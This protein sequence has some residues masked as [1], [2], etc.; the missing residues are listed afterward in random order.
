MQHP[1]GLR[2]S[3]QSQAWAVRM[4]RGF[5]L[6]QL[7]ECMLQPPLLS[8]PVAEPF[9]FELA[10]GIGKSLRA[11]QCCYQALESSE[12]I[13]R[14]GSLFL[15]KLILGQLSIAVHRL[16]SR[17]QSFFPLA[18]IGKAGSH[19][20]QAHGQV[21][22]ECL[23]IF[24]GQLSIAV[25]RLFGCSRAS[26]RRPRSESLLPGCSGSWPGWAGIP[27]DFSLPAFDVCP[28]PLWPP[29]ELLPAAPDRKALLPGCQAVWLSRPSPLSEARSAQISKLFHFIS[30]RAKVRSA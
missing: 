2:Q 13:V 1:R 23:G 20:V 21:G 30:L 16:F 11:W 4:P 26:S 6:G 5:F 7:F 8:S 25:R 18:Q 28:L 9:P 12:P 14:P 19:V 24:L 17:L 29:P 22:Q 27:G 3:S 15:G 10:P